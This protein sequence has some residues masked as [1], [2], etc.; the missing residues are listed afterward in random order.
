MNY[1]KIAIGF[2][3]EELE[4]EV[5]EIHDLGYDAVGGVQVLVTDNRPHFFQAVVR[6]HSGDIYHYL[7]YPSIQM[8]NQEEAE[9]K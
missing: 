6:N 1:Y 2:S 8:N 9:K 5:N 4:R 7:K 3:P